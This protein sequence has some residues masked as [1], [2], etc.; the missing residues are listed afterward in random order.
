MRPARTATSST[1][2]YTGLA[3]G[4]DGSINV[5]RTGL[6]RL[7]TTPQIDPYTGALH[8]GYAH[9]VPAALGAWHL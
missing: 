4:A 5:T 6:N 8:D 7:V 2:D 9:D 3:T 1:D